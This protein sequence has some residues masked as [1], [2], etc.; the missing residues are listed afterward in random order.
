M[1]STHRHT[2]RHPDGS[3]KLRSIIRTENAAFSLLPVVSTVG[4]ALIA[5]L[6]LVESQAIAALLA[7]LGSFSGVVRVAL[8]TAGTAI[9][10]IL[11]VRTFLVDFM[12]NEH[13]S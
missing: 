7:K 1:N 2:L 12:R 13:D 11:A 6:S 10:A 5:L 3:R 4:G 8:V 9:V